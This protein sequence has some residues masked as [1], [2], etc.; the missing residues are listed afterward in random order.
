MKLA[1]VHT[2][3]EGIVTYKFKWLNGYNVASVQNQTIVFWN[4][5]YHNG[6][7]MTDLYRLTRMEQGLNKWSRIKRFENNTILNLETGCVTLRGT[8]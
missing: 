3:T 1:V 4:S 7:K 5:F 2:K 6:K 8:S